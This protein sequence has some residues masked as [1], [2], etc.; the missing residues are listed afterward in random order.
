MLGAFPVGFDTLHEHFFL[1]LTRLIS[2]MNESIVLSSSLIKFKCS[3]EHTTLSSQFTNFQCDLY[4]HMCFLRLMVNKIILKSHC[5]NT[6][7]LRD[8]KGQLV[9]ILDVFTTLFLYYDSI[10]KKAV[11][12]SNYFEININLRL[13]QLYV[14]TTYLQK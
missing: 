1:S 3:N 10:S 2:W 9:T 11:Y 4:Q 6:S 5:T 7:T 13:L 14:L 8:S 12:A